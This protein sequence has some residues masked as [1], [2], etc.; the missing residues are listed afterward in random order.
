MEDFNINSKI[1]IFC[2]IICLLIPLSTV[3]AS[4]INNTADDQVLSATPS[5]DTLSA[6]VNPENN[7]DTLSVQENENLLSA[8]SDSGSDN[9]LGDDGENETNYG[10][11]TDFN[12]IMELNNDGILFLF[13][14]YKYN[15]TVD[16]S[17]SNGIVISKSIVI[18]GQGHTI[19]AN[20]NIA[21]TI[22]ANNVTLK[23]IKILNSIA[24]GV[25]WNG[26]EGTIENVTLRDYTAF[27][28]IRWDGTNGKIKNLTAINMTTGSTG[29]AG[30]SCG[31]ITVYD[32]VNVNITDSYFEDITGAAIV[33]PSGGSADNVL[34]QNCIFNKSYISGL[35]VWDSFILCGYALYTIKDCKFYNCTAM[36]GLIASYFGPM[37]IDH[38]EFYNTTIKDVRFRSQSGGVI[39]DRAGGSNISNCIFENNYVDHNG[40]LNLAGGTIVKDCIFNNNTKIETTPYSGIES[41]TWCNGVYFASSASQLINCIFKNYN[42]SDVPL[43]ATR[44]STLISPL[45]FNGVEIYNNTLGSLFGYDNNESNGN[46]SNLVFDNSKIY[47]NNFTSG[48]LFNMK[49]VQSGNLSINYPNN[50]TLVHNNNG[51]KLFRDSLDVN[52]F[53]IYNELWADPYN[54]TDV[55]N[56]IFIDGTIYLLPGT[57]N[58]GVLSNLGSVTVNKPVTFKGM[59]GVVFNQTRFYASFAPRTIFDSITFENGYID[60]TDS[61]ICK[62]LNCTFNNNNRNVFRF[63][64]SMLMTLNNIKINNASVAITSNTHISNSVFNNW[65]IFNA[66]TEGSSNINLNG[67]TNTFNNF[68][69]LNST[70][71]QLYLDGKGSV[72]N[73]VSIINSKTTVTNGFV[74]GGDGKVNDLFIQNSTATFNDKFLTY[75]VRNL[76]G[77]TFKDI[78][79]V[80]YLFNFGGDASLSNVILDNVTLLE[81]IVYDENVGLELYNFTIKN[82]S[83]MPY[84][85]NIQNGVNVDL[86]KVYDSNFTSGTILTLNGNN[87]VKNSILQD[88]TGHIVVNGNGVKI[89]DSVFIRGNN[90]GLNGSALDVLA[91]GSNLKLVN[92]N[93]TS[94]NATYGGAIYVHFGANRLSF[95]HVNFTDNNATGSDYPSTGDSRYTGPG[96]AI[97]FEYA[98]DESGNV[99]GYSYTMDDYTT[100]TINSNSRFY[101]NVVGNVSSLLS[102]VYVV[103]DTSTWSGSGTA[104]T[105][106]DAGLFE[107]AFMIAG[108]GCT[109]VF[110]RSGDVFNYTNTTKAGIMMPEAIGMSELMD[111]LVFKGNN[112]II[113][114][115]RFHVTSNVNSL[116]ATNI[117][118]TGNE[119]S[120]V[121]IDGSNVRFEDCKFVDNGGD[122]ARF[123]AAVIVNGENAVFRNVTFTN[124]KVNNI[125]DN[126]GFGGALYINASNVNVTDCTFI[127]NGALRSGQHIYIAEKKNKTGI[128]EYSNINIIDST[129]DESLSG[130]SEAGSGVSI[131][132]Y[133]IKVSGCNFTANNANSGSGVGIV[134]DVGNLIFTG[135]NFTKNNAVNGSLYLDF[136]NS[137]GQINNIH[138]N[139]FTDNN[140]ENGGAVFISNDCNF[141]GLIFDE[142]T[143]IKNNAVNGGALY[144]DSALHLDGIT[145]TGNNATNGG[146]VYVNADN[147]ILSSMTFTG[148]NATDGGALYV[149]GNHTRVIDSTFN[150]NNALNHGS[151]VYLADNQ[152]ISL[153]NIQLIGN[154]A[155]KYD[156]PNKEY[157]DI[158]YA[159]ILPGINGNLDV[160]HGSDSV[161]YINRTVITSYSEVYITNGGSGTGGIIDPTDW[162]NAITKILPD[163]IIYIVTDDL[164]V[165]S[166]MITLLQNANLTNVTIVGINKTKITR[167]GDVG[168]YLFINLK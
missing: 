8:G 120:T 83:S 66:S 34:I 13:Q 46:F 129:F 109:F 90:S 41:A 55:L 76:N 33:T 116:T 80:K 107:T 132:G 162:E 150:G 56:N 122:T 84:A 165:N 10:A 15:S 40:V 164:K 69:L 156:K 136:T 160:D 48:Y 113:E 135:N 74:I 92:V 4:D 134:G 91:G 128:P 28:A 57:Y 54:F 166:D 78:K 97:R 70:I 6:S 157:D 60:F 155:A 82:N 29:T 163:G 123:G 1:I 88:Y 131:R 106:E 167:D 98:L 49:S 36:D 154:K 96:G 139:Y 93:F 152:I 7:N 125:T 68:T 22:N 58:D 52:N 19:D 26:D 75:G 137:L 149:N 121:I 35:G 130:A 142:N 115:M 71:N 100:S 141:D 73:N 81:R 101:N 114:N 45:V 133:N 67:V 16:S 86:F 20:G 9:L 148:N 124:N 63:Y 21:F 79:D 12:K 105:P 153:S 27:P 158:S 77:A 138:D 127:G 14:D 151:A 17:F 145:F 23:N 99:L 144:L 65:T 3:S 118:F 87:V 161:Y 24:D 117:T 103:N 30:S 5:V 140:A 25:T 2:L 85:F 72:Y 111:G 119:N 44:N 53:K 50:N 18:D 112:T 95:E 62:V 61:P 37:I 126:G 159:G 89:Q 39:L 32:G 51:A 102:I 146:A 104:R 108:D 59:N 64:H 47:N 31:V 147:T 168:K 94:N 11:F 38:C 110:V 143:Y 43:F 42:Q